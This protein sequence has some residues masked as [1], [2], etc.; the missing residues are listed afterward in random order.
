MTAPANPLCRLAPMHVSTP[1]CPQPSRQLHG[2]TQ[3][4]TATAPSKLP[5]LAVRQL[6]SATT[7]K[8]L[9]ESLTDGPNHI[10]YP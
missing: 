3:S 5:L 4:H 6:S 2:D 7:E 10:Q 8:P 9:T 1:V